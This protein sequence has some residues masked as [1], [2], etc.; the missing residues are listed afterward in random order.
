MSPI[1]AVL[2]WMQDHFPIILVIWMLINAS[3]L[4]D[5]YVLLGIA[6]K[7]RKAAISRGLLPSGPRVKL[8][9]RGIRDILL[10]VVFH[11]VGLAIG[12]MVILGLPTAN[13]S[14]WLIVLM[15]A[16]MAITSRID[17]SDDEEMG[18]I[19]NSEIGERSLFPRMKRPAK[20]EEE[21]VSAQPEAKEGQ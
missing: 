6:K 18:R 4:R 9:N 7:R 1:W 8:A 3:G 21:A 15:A 13:S 20:V 5:A 11:L 12:L 14:G 19:L 17:L 10:R 16:L 2:E